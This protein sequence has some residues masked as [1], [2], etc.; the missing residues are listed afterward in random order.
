MLY[1]KIKAEGLEKLPNGP[2]IIAPNHQS[3]FDGLFVTI[4]I[5]NKVG[6][7]S[8]PPTIVFSE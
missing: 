6:G 7:I 1:F 5:K 4:F 2:F 8:P 3:F